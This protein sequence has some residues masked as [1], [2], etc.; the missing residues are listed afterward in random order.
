[1]PI[2]EISLIL[3]MSLFMSHQPISPVL[4]DDAQSIQHASWV[5]AEAFADSNVS[6]TSV[7]ISAAGDVTIGSDDSFGYYGTFHHEVDESGLEHFGKNVKAIFEQDDLTIVNLETTLTESTQKAEKTFRFSG[8]PE[9]TEILNM[10]GIEA[11][12]LANN[13]TYDF[14]E[15]GYIDTLNN[16]DDYGVASFGYDRLFIE[17]INGMKVGAFGLEGWQ[18]SAETR[19]QVEEAIAQL[20]EQGAQ[21]II[22]NYHWGVERQYHPTESQRTLAQFTIDQGADLVLGH[23]PHVV[24]GIEEYKGKYIVYSLGNFMFGGNRNPDDKDTFIFQQTFHFS[25]NQLT[26]KQDIH[27]I[28]ASISS[29]TERNNYQPTPLEGEEADRV[30]NKILKLSNEIPENEFSYKKDRSEEAVP[31]TTG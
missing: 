19:S 18:D 9:Y 15:Q 3:Y 29:V 27:I 8:K 24:Q 14:L 6:S 1:M 30:L 11:V 25:F 22:A 16:L 12:N 13:H 20:K 17:E 4:L 7:T 23:H 5:H 28:P 10:S 26:D 2:R 31:V 21:I